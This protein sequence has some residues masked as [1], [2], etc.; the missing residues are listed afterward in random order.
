MRWTEASHDVPMGSGAVAIALT[1][2]EAAKMR[3]AFDYRD[4]SVVDSF[5][6]RFED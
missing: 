6:S 2:N 1:D 4:F 3:R 5:V